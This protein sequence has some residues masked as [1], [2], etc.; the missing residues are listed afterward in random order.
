M[1]RQGGELTWY[2]LFAL[3]T[4]NALAW[5]NHHA[6]VCSLLLPIS[7]KLSTNSSN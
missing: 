4:L 1:H 2:D 6:L 3:P 5:G 7:S